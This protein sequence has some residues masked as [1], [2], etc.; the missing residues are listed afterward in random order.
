MSAMPA[1]PT[2]KEQAAASG[3]FDLGLG[4]RVDL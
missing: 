3:K 2:C 4:A 1:M